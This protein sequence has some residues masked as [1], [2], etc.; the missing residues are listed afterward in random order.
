MGLVELV[1]SHFA[2]GPVRMIPFF[3]VWWV[4]LIKLIYSILFFFLFFL[5]GGG[6]LNFS[7]RVIDFCFFVIKHFLVH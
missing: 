7:L 3:F 2:I 6:E 1:A 5:C 4:L